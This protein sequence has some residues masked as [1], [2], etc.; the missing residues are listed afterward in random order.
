MPRKKH[1]KKKITKS[2]VAKPA[3]KK[4]DFVEELAALG[5]RIEGA[6]K[7]AVTSKAA[8]DFQTEAAKSIKSVG[9]KLVSAVEAARKSE[10][11]RGIGEQAKKVFR[12]GKKQGVDT[13]KQAQANLA[14]GLKG[15]S[16][17]L[18]DLA[19]KVKKTKS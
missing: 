9:Q 7:S 2:L 16:K 11:A 3:P 18:K 13:A 6:L 15:L 19:K 5:S 10:D 4:A 12:T 1:N 14:A 8:R 17:E